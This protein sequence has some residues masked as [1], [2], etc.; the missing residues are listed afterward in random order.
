MKIELPY[1]PSKLNPNRRQHHMALAKARKAFRAE[2]GFEALAQGLNH[3]DADSLNLR[4]EF[5]P[6]DRRRRDRDN[7]IAAFKAGQD[8]IADITG[9]DDSKFNITYAPL[10][11]P[12]K[13]GCV[14]VE[15][16]T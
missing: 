15:I 14:T 4:I 3:I 12:I 11:E 8:A 1:P 16:E 9:I 7:L 10:G 13:G 5:R 2:C 6:P